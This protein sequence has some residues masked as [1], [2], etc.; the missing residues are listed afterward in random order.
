MIQ[1]SMQQH[2]ACFMNENPVSSIGQDAWVYLK[3]KKKDAGVYVPGK[4][5]NNKEVN[6]KWDISI[7]LEVL[8]W[9]WNRVIWQSR[10]KGWRRVGFFAKAFWKGDMWLRLKW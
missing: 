6:N 9:R 3:K 5:L 8:Q 1:E 10:P 4:K 2:L 7:Y